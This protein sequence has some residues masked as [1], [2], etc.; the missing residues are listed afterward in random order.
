M[1]RE[2]AEIVWRLDLIVA[3][4]DVE[5]PAKGSDGKHREAHGHCP[6]PH[7]AVP[8][9]CRPSA[10]TRLA[11]RLRSVLRL[12]FP[13][14]GICSFFATCWIR[15]SKKRCNRK[16]SAAYQCESRCQRVQAFSGDSQQ[17]ATDDRQINKSENC[18]KPLHGN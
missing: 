6:E 10:C 15:S 9:D 12:L 2:I 17:K 16:R 1:Q 11:F 4:V 13:F 3:T 14:R 5:Q 8:H 7:T 18:R